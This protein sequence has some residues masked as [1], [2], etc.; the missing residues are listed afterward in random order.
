MALAVA[1]KALRS[2]PS[3]SA[4]ALSRRWTWWRLPPHQGR[5]WLEPGRCWHPGRLARRKGGGRASF[6]AHRVRPR[7]GARP[8]LAVCLLEATR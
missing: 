5:P 6:A 7:P 1:A 4:P 3:M 8:P 2:G